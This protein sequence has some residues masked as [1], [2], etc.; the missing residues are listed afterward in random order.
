MKPE[1]LRALSIFAGNPNGCTEATHARDRA[2]IAQTRP[3]RRCA[4]CGELFTPKRSHAI[5]CSAACKQ[6]AYRDRSK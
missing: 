1:Q 5:Y 3:K 4:I 6:Q 2:R